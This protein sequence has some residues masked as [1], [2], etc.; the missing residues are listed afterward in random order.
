MTLVGRT[1][2]PFETARFGDRVRATASVAFSVGRDKTE[3]IPVDVWGDLADAVAGGVAKGDRVKI[4]GKL[5]ASE[6][7]DKATGAKRRSVRVVADSV[8][9]VV[10]G[11]VAG[12]NDWGDVSQVPTEWGAAPSAPPP[13]RHRRLG[14]RG[15]GWL[16][17]R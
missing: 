5:R 11:P 8:A 6:F 1:G 2:A 3:W 10:D 15:G 4:V 14:G 17:G 16:A 7:V 9:R 13:P 12:G